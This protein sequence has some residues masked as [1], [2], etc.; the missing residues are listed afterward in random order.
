MNPVLILRPKILTLFPNI[1]LEMTP[2]VKQTV[3]IVSHGEVIKNILT[4]SFTGETERSCLMH[5]RRE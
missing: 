2:V 4:G 3:V 5:I 1:I